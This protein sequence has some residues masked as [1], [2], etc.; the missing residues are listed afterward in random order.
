L[1]RRMGKAFS[2]AH[3]IS[4]VERA[5]YIVV[6]EPLHSYYTTQFAGV[7]SGRFAGDTLTLLQTL[8]DEDFLRVQ[9]NLI[10]HMVV[11]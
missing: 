4:A 11:H 1:L 9:D 3:N 2:R 7:M 8:C 5:L 6:Q 10:W